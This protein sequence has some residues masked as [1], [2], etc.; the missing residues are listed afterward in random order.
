M[1]VRTLSCCTSDCLNGEWRIWKRYDAMTGCVCLCA[2]VQQNAVSDDVTDDERRQRMTRGD[3][4]LDFGMMLEAK[5]VQAES[6]RT[7]LRVFVR[8]VARTG[9]AQ[10]YGIS[11]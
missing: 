10:R 9:A 7:A 3:H 4:E 2:C 5:L 6:G 1:F 11:Q 8:D